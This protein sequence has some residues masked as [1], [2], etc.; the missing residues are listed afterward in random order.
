MKETV[1]AFTGSASGKKKTGHQ[2]VAVKYVMR[3]CYKKRMGSI[4]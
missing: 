2:A 3:T 4:F 1:L